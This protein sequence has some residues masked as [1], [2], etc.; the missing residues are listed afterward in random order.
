[1]GLW[2]TAKVLDAVAKGLLTPEEAKE[3]LEG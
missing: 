3:I 1:M 2:N